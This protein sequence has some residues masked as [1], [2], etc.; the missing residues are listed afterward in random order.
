MKENDYYTQELYNLRTLGKAFSLKNPGLSSFL[1]E[2]GQDPDVERLLEGFAFLTGKLRQNMDQEFPELTHGLTQLMWTN[3]MQ[4]LPSYTI[5]AFKPE[6]G[7]LE[8]QIIEKNTQLLSFSQQYKTECPFF[9]N[10]AID[11]HP[12]ELEKVNYFTNGYSSTI[13]L[14]F[15][16]TSGGVLDNLQLDK[17]RF[18]L[19]GSEFVSQELHLFLHRYVT[20][21]EVSIPEL[22]DKSIGFQLD[23]RVIKSVGFA[24]DENI[25]PKHQNVFHAYV[26]MQEYFCYRD[27]F[28]FVDIEGFE[29]LRGLK[30]DVLE[31]QNSFRVSI[32]FNRH[33][34][35]AD[36]LKLENFRLFCTPAV[37]LIETASIPLRKTNKDEE[38][39]IIPADLELENTEV[40]MIKRVE[41]WTEDKSK[42]AY[43]LPFGSFEHAELN[44]EFY[45]TKVKLSEDNSRLRTFIRLAPN[46]VEHDILLNKSMVIT[47][48]ILATNKNIPSTLR[49]GSVNALHSSAKVSNL[50]LENITI[51]SKSYLP[52]LEGDF[53]WR[54]ISNMSLNYLSL[55]NISTFR[56]LIAAYDFPGMTDAF[57]HRRTETL[58]R[59]LS[60]I[61]YKTSEMIYKGLPIRGIETTIE[62]D[63]DCY[64]SLGE[65]YIFSNVLN[66][67][68]TLY[69]NL[70]TF[71][72][73]EVKI[74]RYETFTWEARLGQQSL[75]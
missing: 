30:S 52:P 23:E 31:T 37:N 67:F 61:S 3:Y 24:E 10:Y 53:L 7:K 48:E 59:G 57:F 22:H 20:N 65:A 45:S 75:M 4:P 43:F 18:Y 26:L 6:K 2:K 73:L 40:F 46:T 12:I 29:K 64:A 19:G 50:E 5:V 63:P 35:I 66:D 62:L 9:T 8:K 11:L 13:E 25:L 74:D 54:L 51:P 55:G 71:H 32:N 16:V 49:L 56:T 68:L 69:C 38:Y 15:K 41:G 42:Y 14:D 28:N 39:E 36:D 70:N 27:K 72:R 34:S 58:L 60:K 47:V 33:L 1:S 44:Q 21:I 17:L